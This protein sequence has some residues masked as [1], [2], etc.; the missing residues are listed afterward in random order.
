MLNTRKILII[1]LLLIFTFLS[2]Y[3]SFHKSFWRDEVFSFLLSSKNP[4]DII[5][6]TSKDFTPPLFYL[7]LHPF[8]KLFGQNPILLRIL[9]LIFSLF[10]LSLLFKIE[11]I[12]ATKFKLSLSAEILLLFLLSSNL[13]LFY[14][15]T[16]TR[17]Y[18][19]FMFLSLLS[20]FYLY[21]LIFQ[22]KQKYFILFS[23]VNILLLYT[24]NLSI[25][26]LV[27]QFISAII[28]LVSKKNISAIKKV[29]LSYII[30]FIFISPWLGV[31]FRQTQNL[32]NSF[33]LDLTQKE[34]I[35]E[36]LGIFFINENLTETEQKLPLFTHFL[37]YG[38]ILTLSGIIITFK[39][40]KESIIAISNFLLSLVLFYFIST[41]FSQI[42]YQR[43]LAF[44]VP[45]ST[46]LISL[47]LVF[48]F[49]KSKLIFIP[50]FLLYLFFNFKIMITYLQ[51]PYKID[52][53]KIEDQK[54]PV[55]TDEDVLLMP[56]QFYSQNCIYVGLLNNSPRYLGIK[57]I[58]IKNFDT[59]N[60]WQE[61]NDKRFSVLY[62]W[63]LE[64]DLKSLVDQ[65]YYKIN[66]FPMGDNLIFTQ[67][68]KIN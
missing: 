8:I 23:L 4:I 63:E 42:L 3:V 24:H 22:F 52:F 36:Y 49:I 51:K 60:S 64:E 58:G 31:F 41:Y 9:P 40:K 39:K 45:F 34:M 44:L 59:L 62:Y 26:F 16:E 5:I 65:K 12:I 54:I 11:K 30:V 2:F 67:F 55:Y 27:S 7:L 29:I 46:L 33:W 61:I 38:S 6:S 10:T 1:I 50:F 15:S 47:T 28:Y 19:L 43:Y 18:S 37:V 13:S 68:E 20:I 14:F 66:S 17:A 57:Q 56:C 48:I 53:Q 35:H 21:H 32:E 25:I